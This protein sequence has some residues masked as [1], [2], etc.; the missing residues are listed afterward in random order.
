MVLDVLY[1][2]LV[3]EADDGGDLV[4]GARACAVIPGTAGVKYLSPEHLDGGYTYS[5]WDLGS[6]MR[7]R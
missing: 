1:M 3:Y 6:S 2:V 7:R 4:E 5:R